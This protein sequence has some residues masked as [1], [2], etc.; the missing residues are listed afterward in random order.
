MPNMTTQVQNNDK[1]TIRDNHDFIKDLSPLTNPITPTNTIIVGAG[2]V[3]LCT[4]YHLAK[5]NHHPRD[6]TA[7]HLHKVNE[8]QREEN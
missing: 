3:G 5:A 2:I 6:D 1:E 4:A 7:V 8:R